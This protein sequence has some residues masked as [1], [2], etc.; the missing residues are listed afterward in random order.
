MSRFNWDD[1]Q[2]F[3]ETQR[4]GRLSGAGK[5]LRMSHTTVARR[6]S[7][8]ERDLGV[9]LFERKEDG[10]KL[11]SE[12]QKLFAYAQKM[13]DLAVT[14]DDLFSV[15]DEKITGSVR[16]GAPDG[17]GNAFLS[18][19]LPAMQRDHPELSIELVPIPTVHKLWKREVDIA[20]SLDRPQTGRIVMRKLTNY[21]L[22][23]FASP[24]LI[25]QQ[26]MPRNR[27]ELKR[28]NFVGYVDDLLYTTELDFNRAIDPG[29]RI[30]YKG[31]TIKAQYDAIT[32]GIGLGVLPA[33]MTRDCE[34][35]QVLPTQITFLRTYWLLIPE[36]LKELEKIKVTAA[37][38]VN[39][40]KQRAADF[41]FPDSG[42]RQAPYL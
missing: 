8:L 20:V 5:R 14:V 26:G 4:A 29:L 22:R 31:A 40:T 23:I 25:S 27:A 21:E 7:R 12:G 41:F 36:D 34:L 32:A 10:L 38:I 16:V 13:E 24:K 11:T 42:T 17:F 9:V 19:T 2:F 6:L 30:T 33:F 35:V 28:Y 15:S 18:H 1:L 3:L 37:Y 39:A